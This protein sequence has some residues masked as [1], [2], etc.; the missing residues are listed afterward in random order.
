MDMKLHPVTLKFSGECAH[1]EEPF[2]KDY[3]KISLSQI[4]VFLILGALLYAAFGIL[5]ALLMPEQKLMVWLVRFIVI[6][7]GLITVLLISFTDVF[8][9][10]MQGVLSF[11][12]TLAGFGI[13]T[14]IVIAPPPV[15]HAYYAGLM[16]VFTWGYTLIRL[17]FIWASLAGWLQV[18]LYEV[19]AVW[20]NPTPLDIFIGNNFF[21]I[22]ANL[23]GM[24]ACYAIEF[25][26]RRDFFMKKQLETE[27]VN[28]RKINEELEDRVRQ[29]T[30]DYQIVNQALKKE[31]RG[32][33]K[34]EEALRISEEKYRALVENANDLVFR[35]D[36]EG[37]LVFFNIST[38]RIL[39]YDEKEILGKSYLSLVRPDMREEA[40]QFFGRQI[41]NGIRNTYSEYPV[42]KK[43]GSEIWLGQNTQLIMEDGNVKGFQAVS[44]DVTE[45][46]RLERELK[47]SE[48]RYRELSIVDDLTQLYNS[49]HFYNQLKGEIDR[50]ER[51]EYPLTLL[52]LDIDDFK[53]YNDSYGH[54][55]G[56][57][58]LFRLGQIIKRCLRK[59]DSAYRYGGEEFTIILPMTLQD[60][61]LVT[62][63]RIRDELKKENFSP[64]S[65]QEIYLTVSIGLAQYNK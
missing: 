3:H 38:V 5:D 35:T 34:A 33:Q 14:M 17:F 64:K 42:V 61:G 1:L 57:N 2:L 54:I 55:E 12:F 46:R 41:K 43:D 26:A 25:Y 50:I 48:E 23:V 40:L 27:K 6:G 44:R 4:R 37:Q 63:E 28:V 36:K 19:A 58:V 59:E 11:A 18:V 30:M 56:D 16:L 49:R 8:R 29:R 15:S 62:A 47:A 51:R 13:I 32:H 24:M 21:F 45:R 65:D 7:P 31:V 20:V 60:E 39:G 52:L 53:V 9:K 10:Y 22:S